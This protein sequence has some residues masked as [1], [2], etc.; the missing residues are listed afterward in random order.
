MAVRN[1]TPLI[2]YRDNRV[3]MMSSSPT[4]R[5]D[6]IFQQAAQQ[7]DP[8]AGRADPSDAPTWFGQTDQ[9]GGQ[10]VGQGPVKDVAARLWRD[11]Y[12]MTGDS[13]FADVVGGITNGEGGFSGQKDARGATGLFQ[14]R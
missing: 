3:A 13:T 14:S 2:N 1:A 7:Q 5:M 11:A 4:G 9:S 10:T 12:A 8:L 6:N